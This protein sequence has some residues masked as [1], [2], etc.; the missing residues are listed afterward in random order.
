MSVE[1]FAKLLT[2]CDVSPL[3]LKWFPVWVERYAGYLGQPQTTRLDVNYDLVVGYLRSLRDL[4][5]PAWQ[6]LQAA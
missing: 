5:V 2:N 3:S 4:Q 1:A 6:R